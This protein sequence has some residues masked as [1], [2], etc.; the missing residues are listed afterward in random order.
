MEGLIPRVVDWLREV[1]LGFC[2]S[3]NMIKG[4]VQ[5]VGSGLTSVYKGLPLGHDCLGLVVQ[6]LKKEGSIEFQLTLCWVWAAIL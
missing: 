4:M 3:D 2:T 5:Q 6:N 1:S